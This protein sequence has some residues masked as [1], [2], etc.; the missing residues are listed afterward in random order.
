MTKQKLNISTLSP[1]EM[2]GQ[3]HPKC[4]IKESLKS[5]NLIFLN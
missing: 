2:S 4:Q 5:I 1:R 3:R